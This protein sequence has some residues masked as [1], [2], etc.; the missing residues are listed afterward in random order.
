M[1]RQD[2]PEELRARLRWAAGEH[3]PDRERMW[4][5]IERGMAPSPHRPAA[6]RAG[7]P[8]FPGRLRVAGATAAVVGVLGAGGF[9]VASAVRDDGGGH[10]T[11]VARTPDAAPGSPSAP[12][13][14]GPVPTPTASAGPAVPAAPSSSVSASSPPARRASS[15]PAGTPAARTGATDGPLRSD[16]SVSP[17]SNAFWAQSDVTLRLGE[18]LVALTVEVRI[19]RTGGVRDAGA[20]TSLPEQDFTLGVD[21]RDGALVYTWMLREGRTVPAGEWV[22]AAQYDHARG[23]RDAG[24]D[25]YTATALTGDGQRLRVQGR[26]TRGRD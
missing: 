16:G 13:A 15:S 7:L 6:R 23:T 2:P 1:R 8:P 10:R 21:R 9:A 24:A 26:F 14:P 11:V 17:D 4:A 25:R 12:A 19:G 3:R 5:R 18:E 22:F 20:W